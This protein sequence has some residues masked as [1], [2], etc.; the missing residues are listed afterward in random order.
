MI[1]LFPSYNRLDQADERYRNRESRTEDLDLIATLQQTIASYQEQLKKIHDEKKYLKMEL[2]N[3]ETNF[4][5]VF[6]N[7]PSSNIGVMN[8]LSYNTKFVARNSDASSSSRI[9]SQSP[10]PSK[11]EPLATNGEI[12]HDLALNHNKPLLPKRFIK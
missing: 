10:R 5:K 1:F 7:A 4:N 9:K 2:M 6:T 8:P 12:P 11:L 3:R